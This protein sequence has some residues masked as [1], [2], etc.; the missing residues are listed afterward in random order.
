MA[1][2]F[3]EGT[4]AEYTPIEAPAERI[5]VTNTGYRPTQPKKKRSIGRIISNA[6]LILGLLM[7][8]AAGIMWGRAQFGY[9]QQDQQNE[10]LAQFATVYDEQD[11]TVRPPTIDWEG[12]RAINGDVV[13]WIY[14]PGTVINYPVYQG[15]DNDYYLDTNAEGQY[16]VG[17]QI[18]MDFENTAPGMQDQQ[19]I[20]YGHHLKNGAMFKQIA[21]MENQEFFNSI[22]SVWYI[23]EEQNYELVPLM[24]YY[25]NPYDTNVRQFNFAS[26][27]D[28][29]LYLMNLLASSVASNPDAAQMI[30]KSSH[31]LTLGTCNYIDGYGRT[32]LVCV[33]KDE[34]GVA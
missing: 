11:G 33:P 14:V 25:T 24:V 12:L 13:G 21:D 1:S 10:R 15:S 29:Y 28:Y 4:S 22:K 26:E 9:I 8:I 19:T 16:G 17:G 23:T 31:V 3:K 34:V 30:T 20:I 32:L 7:L 27:E 18:F 6:L 2:H 5:P